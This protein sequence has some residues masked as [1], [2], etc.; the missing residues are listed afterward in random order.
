VPIWQVNT[1]AGPLLWYG[2]FLMARGGTWG[3]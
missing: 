2:E 3:Y 1:P